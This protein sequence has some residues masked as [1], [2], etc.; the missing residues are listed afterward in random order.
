MFVTDSHT[1]RV[2][3]GDVGA[4]SH[5]PQ[6]TSNFLC[7]SGWFR[8]RDPPSPPPKGLGLPHLRISKGKDTFHHSALLL[9]PGLHSYLH[10]FYR[11]EDICRYPLNCFHVCENDPHFLEKKPG[12]GGDTVFYLLAGL[13]GA[14]GNWL[15]ST[16][17]G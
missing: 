4:G 12:R 16:P 3:G 15:C 11:F 8:N 1:S 7:T 10:D 9:L 6:L 2:V 5:T 14:S 13:S 17:V